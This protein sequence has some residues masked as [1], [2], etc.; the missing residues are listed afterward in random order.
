MPTYYDPI[1]CDDL[2]FNQET[3]IYIVKI[4]DFF[5]IK[6]ISSGLELLTKDP[7]SN[8]THYWLLDA[9]KICAE[10][11][12]NQHIF[13][14]G[15][16]TA[17]LL[18][19]QQVNEFFNIDTMAQPSTSFDPNGVIRGQYLLQ[20]A[21]DM[22]DENPDD[23]LFR[24]A[25]RHQHGQDG[26]ANLVEAIILYE[27]AIDL[28]NAGAMVNRARMHQLGQGGPFNFDEAIRLYDD[29]IERGNGAAMVNRASMHQDG[30]GG[31]V[32]FD[33]AIEL[34]ERAIL[35]NH[36]NALLNRAL[37]HQD[38]LGG[39]VDFDAAIGLYERAIE[40]GDADAMVNRGL[41]YEY[42]QGGE[43]NLE[44][45]LML[46]ERSREIN[47]DCLSVDHIDAIKANIASVRN[48]TYSILFF[49]RNEVSSPCEDDAVEKSPKR[50]KV[51]PGR[52]S[53]YLNS[54][55]FY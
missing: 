55:D 18:T 1:L 36:D 7:T 17:G 12:D 21:Q 40:H 30:Q 8:A 3:V 28:G 19:L 41:M 2:E 10:Q 35:L 34:Y 11:L 5:C 45:A 13:I 24:R 6:A 51:D 37:M 29:A 4:E 33:A 23:E 14:E 49:S 48:D 39:E 43:V 9:Q 47:A 53:S 25:V 44:K 15:K 31:V 38:G 27:Q 42:G 26:E 54:K 20:Y 50:L 16:L 52:M 32:N 46:F 22:A